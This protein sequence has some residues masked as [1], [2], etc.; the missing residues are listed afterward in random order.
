MVRKFFDETTRTAYVVGRSLGCSRYEMERCIVPE[1]EKDFPGIGRRDISL[2]VL[3]RNHGTKGEETVAGTGLRFDVPSDMSVP[4]EYGPFPEHLVRRGEL[5]GKDTEEAFTFYRIEHGDMVFSVGTVVGCTLDGL[6]KL[7]ALQD[8]EF[9]DADPK[10][11]FFLFF[12]RGENR[13][14]IGL[15]FMTNRIGLGGRT[16]AVKELPRCVP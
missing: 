9:P 16:P 6:G 12:S 14:K 10:Q 3:L 8:E 15:R 7:F 2:T 5:S 11:S 13:G 1:I 4:L